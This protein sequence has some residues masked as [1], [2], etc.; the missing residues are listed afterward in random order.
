MEFEFLS[1]NY[2]KA[3]K[4]LCA[5]KLG[6]ASQQFDEVYNFFRLTYH[7]KEVALDDNM[8]HLSIENLSRFNQDVIKNKS[9]YGIDLPVWFTHQQDKR[10]KIFLLSMDPLRGVDE[11]EGSKASLNSP[12]TIHQKRG[13]NYFPSIEKLACSY[14][15]YVTDV[16]KLFYREAAD[17]TAVSNESAEFVSQ[18]IHLEILQA[19]LSLFKPDIILCLGKHAIQGLAQLGHFDPHHSI[20]SELR[21]FNFQGI[22]TF[23]IPHASGV[24][25]RWAKTFM[26]LNGFSDYSQKKYILDAMDLIVNFIRKH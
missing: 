11:G 4:S 14:D 21:D 10:L 12:F 13:N 6:L 20:V 16:Y 23:A 19:E 7:S 17:V 26:E 3:V 22:P 15:L 18:P 1:D 24:A 8:R 5:E 9:S 25:S 2:L